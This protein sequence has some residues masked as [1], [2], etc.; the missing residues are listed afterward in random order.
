MPP[1]CQLQLPVYVVGSCSNTAVECLL[2]VVQS[3]VHLPC[4]VGKARISNKRDVLAKGS[5]EIVTPN[6]IES[7]RRSSFV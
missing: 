5:L 6:F 2:A 3:H 7:S 1:R 4:L